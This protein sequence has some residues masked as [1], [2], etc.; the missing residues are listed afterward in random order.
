MEKGTP[1]FH[2]EA[3]HDPMGRFGSRH[4]VLDFNNVRVPKENM[5]L[6]QG[7]G[8]QVLTDALNIERLGVAAGAIGTARSALYS[9]A[10][11]VTRR[12]AFGKTLSEIPGVQTMGSDMVTGVTLMFSLGSAIVNVV[13]EERVASEDKAPLL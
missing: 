8:W 2:V 3:I 13:E 6:N 1:G 4:A 7:D 12:V 9:T 5:I 10:D 11:Y